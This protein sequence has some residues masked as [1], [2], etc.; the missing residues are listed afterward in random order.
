MEKGPKFVHADIHDKEFDDKCSCDGSEI[1]ETEEMPPV[2]YP[3][4]NHA[5]LITEQSRPMEESSNTSTS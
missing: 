3:R 2:K 1:M 4:S 5:S